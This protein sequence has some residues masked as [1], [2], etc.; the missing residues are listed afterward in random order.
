M[1]FRFVNR[2]EQKSSGKKKDVG[3]TFKEIDMLKRT[4]T[5][6]KVEDTH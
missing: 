4:F 3:L 5:G 6:A 1:R 2:S